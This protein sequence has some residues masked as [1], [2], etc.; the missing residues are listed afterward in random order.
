MKW[1]ADNFFAYGKYTIKAT[2]ALSASMNFDKFFL[3]QGT[4]MFVYNNNGEMIT[5]PIT[6]AENNEAM[7]WGSWVYKGEFLNIEIKT[8]LGLK[9]KLILHANNVA[10]GYKEIYKVASFGQSGPCNINV[11]CPLGNGWEGESNSVALILRSDGRDLCSGSMVMNTCNT[12]KPYFLTANHC[13]EEDGNVGGWR[14][15]FQAW[16]PTCT[17]SE[18]SDGVT[19]NGSAL[20]ARNAQTDFC[21]V[22]LNNPPP[23]NSNIHYAGWN[24]SA[25][26]ATQA[27]GIHHPSGDV[28]KISRAD[29]AVTVG[30]FSGTTNQHWRANWSPQNNGAGQVVTPVTEG[31]S[32]GSP[33]FDQ[34]HRIVGQLNGGPSFCS[35]SQLWD[36]YG[37]FDLSWTGGGTNATRLSNWLDPNNSGAVTTNTT[38]I[39]NLTNVFPNLTI[40]GP[41]DFCSSATYTA[42]NPVGTTVVWSATSGIVDINSSTGYATKVSDGS[43]FIT[44]TIFYCGTTATVSKLV[45]VGVP[46][47]YYIQYTS[48][49]YNRLDIYPSFTGYLPVVTG[50]YVYVDG[51]FSTSGSGTPPSVISAYINGCSSG[52]VTLTTYNS[53]GSYST[54]SYYSGS[55][56]YALMPNPANDNVTITDMAVS[57]KSIP[58][59][60]K[61]A[62]TVFDNTNRPLKQFTF[63]KSSRYNFSVAGLT[64]GFYTVQIKQNGSISSLKLIKE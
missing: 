21:L 10:Y 15:T 11:L 12:N 22:E 5:G 58:T 29:N 2:G 64:P 26:A 25:T 39:A 17:P 30:S 37:R 63:S 38:N 35:G 61:V 42:N 19:F 40:S 48:S 16:S 51:N 53:C 13:F 20:R 47:N 32:S 14:F 46:N 24:R 41:D 62:I 55:G 56:C 33:L 49:N 3:P 6:D 18:N 7:K 31:G 50:W 23:A 34:N 54:S 52:E 27:T 1:T 36:F 28:M 60:D 45:K 4:E 8:P 59:G 43:A 57:S 44:A 9:D